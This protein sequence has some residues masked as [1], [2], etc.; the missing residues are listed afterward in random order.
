[1]LSLAALVL[2]AASSTSAN[3]VI[4]PDFALVGRQAGVVAPN[5]TISIDPA[6]PTNVGYPGITR[7]GQTPFLAETDRLNST[8]TRS[9]APFEDRYQPASNS[10]SDSSSSNSSSS[11]SFNIL[12]NLGNTVSGDRRLD[13]RNFVLMR[14]APP[15]L[16]SPYFPSPLFPEAQQYRQIDPSCSIQ[17]VHILHRHGDRYP[18]SFSTEGA[19]FFG[20]VIANATAN[21]TSGGTPFVTTGPLSFLT[22]WKYE[23]GAEILTPSGAQELFDSGI[24]SYY[25][26]G[27]LYN[28]TTQAHKPVVRTTSQQRMIDS[29]R[30]WTSGFFGLDAPNLINLEVIFEGDGFK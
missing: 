10:S 5:V 27:R 16:Q 4:R 28:A 17:Q 7:Q 15:F 13:P 21:S 23:L 29:A 30:Y 3:P 14:Q 11:S 22:S 2:L 12:Q 19:P 26:Y 20:Q 6:F 18:T 25:D 24:K 9:N 8:A 1:M